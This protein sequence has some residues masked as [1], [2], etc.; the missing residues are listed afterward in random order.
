MNVVLTGKLYYI[1]LQKVIKH[2]IKYNYNIKCIKFLD[3][4]ILI[5]LLDD[6]VLICMRHINKE[7]YEDKELIKKI[8][9]FD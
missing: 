8:A 9:K 2:E 4:D 6:N 3:K 7:F 1:T 5:E